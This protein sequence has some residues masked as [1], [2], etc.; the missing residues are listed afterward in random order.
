VAGEFFK[1]IDF[2]DAIDLG[3]DPVEYAF[4]FLVRAFAE[5]RSLTFQSAFVAEKLLPVKIGDEFPF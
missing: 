3:N 5:E 4:N 2:A 1:I